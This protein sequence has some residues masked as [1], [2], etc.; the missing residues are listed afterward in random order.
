MNA[1]TMNEEVSLELCETECPSTEGI[2][3][4]KETISDDDMIGMAEIFKA[5]ADPTRVKVAYMLDRGGELCVC[6]VAEVL[7][8]STATA[9]HHLRT[10][11]NKDIAKS[12]KAGK[13]V[14]YSLKD[15]HI[16]T[17]LHMTLEHQKEKM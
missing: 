5:L 9:S 12:R 11:K 4:L 10:L 16:R 8:S 15:D 2:A 3:L 13:N 17:L 7:G 6:D 14:Y 1:R